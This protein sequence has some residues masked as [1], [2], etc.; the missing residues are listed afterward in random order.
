LRESDLRSFWA[1]RFSLREYRAEGGERVIV[2]FPG[3]ESEGAGPDF[4]G[5]IVDLDGVEHRGEVEV[6]RRQE[7]WKAHGHHKDPRY[8]G[9]IL[10]VVLHAG[11]VGART[12]SG[13][14]VPTVS[15]SH[16]LGGLLGSFVKRAKGEARRPCPFLPSPSALERALDELGALRLRRKASRFGK[17]MEEGK[18]P[19]QVF[20]EG[21]AEALGYIRNRRPMLELARALPFSEA[22]ATPDPLELSRRLLEMA[23]RIRGWDIWGI[24]PP[25]FP[26]PRI[27]G[28]AALVSRFARD[29]FCGPVLEALSRPKELPRLFYVKGLIGTGRARVIAVN[30]AVP[31]ALA[32]RPEMGEQA[33]RAWHSLPPEPEN[34]ILRRMK[35]K[36]FSRLREGPELLRKSHIRQG[37]IEL[38]HRYCFLP[39]CDTCPIR[40]AKADRDG[41]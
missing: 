14:A 4:Q 34:R 11:G 37:A 41:P 23:S 19:D 36:L 10:H 30:V 9:V 31:F 12:L 15:L 40:Q 6:H 2:K 33:L 29:G 1:S 21:L 13:R 22:R 39:L 16:N 25:N 35:E 18:S 20:Y 27:K 5:A 17:E 8:E 26:L 28:L 24:R 38:H 32:L 3:F 7:D